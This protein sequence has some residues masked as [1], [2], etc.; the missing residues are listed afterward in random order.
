MRRGTAPLRKVERLG[1]PRYCRTRCFH[2]L[3]E[4]DWQR[5]RRGQEDRVWH[6]RIRC[7]SAD[8][9]SLVRVLVSVS[10][11]DPASFL[12]RQKRHRAWIY[13]AAACPAAASFQLGPFL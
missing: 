3:E 11:P 10:R 13:P 5:R 2:R 1:R 9:W 6:S 8:E 12:K 4:V 7:G